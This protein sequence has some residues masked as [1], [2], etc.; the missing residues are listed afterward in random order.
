[1]LT[2]TRS[3]LIAALATV[4]AAAAAQTPSLFVSPYIGAAVAGGDEAKSGAP[5]VGLS[6]GWMGA[7]WGL[8]GDVAHT[9][10]FFEQD[11]FRTDRRV[12]SAMASGLY[13][14]GL[15][16]EG[17][18]SAY[19]AAGVGVIGAQLAEAGDL[20]RIDVTQPAFN[21]GGG[22]LWMRNA[23][24]IRGDVRYVRAFGDEADDVNPFGLGVSTLDFV[25]ISV[26]LVVGF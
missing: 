24:G 21:V 14:M 11:G 13:R 18:V 22:L 6:A 9:N 2:F 16:N 26:G 20:A 10:G 4:P 3:V 17:A 23:M 1:M 15:A 19:A 25:R 12:K 8:E 7:R 5:T